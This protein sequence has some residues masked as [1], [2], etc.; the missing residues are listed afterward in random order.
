M[1]R[2]IL[3][4]LD[5][6]YCE[7]LDGG[8]NADLYSDNAKSVLAKVIGY[9]KLGSW[10]DTKTENIYYENGRGCMASSFFVLIQIYQFQCL[11]FG[12]FSPFLPLPF[13]VKMPDSS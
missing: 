11:N 2:N 5:L 8:S 12:R 9:V 4:E 3:K 13:R 7:I 6:L 10:T 1:A